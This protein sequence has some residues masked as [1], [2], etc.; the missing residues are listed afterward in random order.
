MRLRRTVTALIYP[1]ADAPCFFNLPKIRQVLLRA[2]LQVP[3]KRGHHKPAPLVDGAGNFPPSQSP[4]FRGEQT[5]HCAGKLEYSVVSM[6]PRA[7][8]GFLGR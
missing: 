5:R 4:A 3:G 2:A 8:L 6:D 7:K 1:I